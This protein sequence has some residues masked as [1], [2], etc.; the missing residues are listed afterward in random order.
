MSG[1]D[2]YN[3]SK[4]G[5]L[6]EAKRLLDSGADINWEDW[7]GGYNVWDILYYFISYYTVMCTVVIDMII[8]YYRMEIQL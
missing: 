2:L 6:T 4:K 5:D 3:A 7:N 8:I 1:K